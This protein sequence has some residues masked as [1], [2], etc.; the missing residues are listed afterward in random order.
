M[1]G[2]GKIAIFLA[3]RTRH[4]AIGILVSQPG[5][6]PAVRVLRPNHWTVREFPRW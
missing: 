5:I 1:M 6:E 4:V 2:V 3:G